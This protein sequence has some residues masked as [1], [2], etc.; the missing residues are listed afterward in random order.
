MPIP[1]QAVC[2]G[3]VNTG[4]APFRSADGGYLLF[5]DEAV[6]HEKLADLTPSFFLFVWSLSLI[7]QS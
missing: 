2:F 1:I 4:T 5:A 6:T 3:I 7:P